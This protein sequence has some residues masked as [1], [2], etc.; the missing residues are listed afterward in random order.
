M[1]ERA[2]F[3]PL[4]HAA[5]F[6]SPGNPLLFELHSLFSRSVLLGVGDVHKHD[7]AEQHQACE[8]EDDNVH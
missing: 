1:G 3:C 6:P 8:D 2:L 5:E 7:Q 4:A